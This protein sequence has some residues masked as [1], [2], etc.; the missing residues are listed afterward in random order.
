MKTRILLVDDECEYSS[1]LKGRLEAAGYFDVREENNELL[2]VS[3]A[4]EFAPDIVLLDVMMP[5]L[6]GSEVAARFRADRLLRDVPILFLT[7][8]VSE[9]DAPDGSCS[10]GGNTF[11]PK[12]LSIEKLMDCIAQ[13][14]AL[15][16]RASVAV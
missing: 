14:I 4:R 3:A 7:A 15:S 16:R 12:S 8:L 6:E 5:H 9:E 13:A 11:L 10:S 2:A 1:M